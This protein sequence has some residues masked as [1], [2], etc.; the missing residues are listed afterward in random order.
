[1]FIYYMG[2]VYLRPYVYYFCQ[3]FQ[4]LC[5]FPALRLFLR[6]EYS[7]LNS[8]QLNFSSEV[9]FRSV[10]QMAE[11]LKL[12][13]YEWPNCSE[14]NKTWIFKRQ[15]KSQFCCIPKSRRKRNVVNQKGNYKSY[16]KVVSIDTSLFSKSF[17]L[18]KTPKMTIF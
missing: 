5:L 16:R 18:K 10:P 11:T 15:S 14:R 4:A 12:I 3:I 1:M 17:L 2:H 9:T 7:P 8:A 6:L 13:F